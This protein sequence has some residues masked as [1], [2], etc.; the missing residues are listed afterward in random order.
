MPRNKSF[1]CINQRSS[2]RSRVRSRK[3]SEKW[4]EIGT[5]QDL[6]AIIS[7]APDFLLQKLKRLS[8]SSNEYK[9]KQSKTNRNTSRTSI[10]TS[11]IQNPKISLK[12]ENVLLKK[13]VKEL[14]NINQSLQKE[15]LNLRK[16][17][18]LSEMRI[19]ELCRTQ[20]HSLKSQL[21]NCDKELHA[22]ELKYSKIRKEYSQLEAELIA[23]KSQCHKDKYLCND[24]VAKLVKQNKIL[25]KT[26]QELKQEG[27]YIKEN[28]YNKND[29]NVSNKENKNEIFS[30]QKEIKKLQY[31]V[32]LLKK[33]YNSSSHDKLFGG[34]LKQVD[35]SWGNQNI[36]KSFD[37]RQKSYSQ[38]PTPFS[39]RDLNLHNNHSIFNNDMMLEQMVES[40]DFKENKIIESS[41][42]GRK[43]SARS[44]L[45]N[46][47]SNHR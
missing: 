34:D 37:K 2:N 44:E 47:I 42:L 23:Y 14:L 38:C 1:S 39:K 26:I 18:K 24:K 29:H 41:N 16:N 21:K 32:D 27:H 45:N 10:N 30:Y 13:D 43:Y 19:Y 25:L 15:I 31:E 11:T 9:R 5:E 33:N 35:Q 40:P 12:K 4:S 17:Q 28:Q 22:K 8:K 7:S 46:F 36:S 20:I 6:S 3:R